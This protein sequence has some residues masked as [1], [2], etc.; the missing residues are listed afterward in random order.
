MKKFEVKDKKFRLMAVKQQI[1]KNVLKFFI[2]NSMTDMY[3]RTIL[4]KKLSKL[5][6]NRFFKTS[7]KNVCIITGRSRGINYLG[8]SRIKIREYQS[9]GIICGLK[10]ISW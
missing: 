3:E 5:N 1:R 7:C 9:M 2:Y 8:L 10:K 6:K 4:Y